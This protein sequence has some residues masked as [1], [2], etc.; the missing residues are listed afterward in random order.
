MHE[1]MLPQVAAIIA[2]GL[3]QVRVAAA[4]GYTYQ[5]WA[6]DA[7]AADS[8]AKWLIR[9]IDAAGSAAFADATRDF[10]KVWDSRATYAYA[11]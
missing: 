7:A 1:S 5:A 2:A 11:V 3:A 10:T 4:G 8:D 6:I 9:R